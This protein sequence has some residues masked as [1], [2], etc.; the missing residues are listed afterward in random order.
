MI[1]DAFYTTFFRM[2]QDAFNTAF[3][4]VISSSTITDS[5][6]LQVVTLWLCLDKFGLNFSSFPLHQLVIYT[7][8][9]SHHL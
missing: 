6:T 4:R 2:I 1:Q 7:T 9:Q 3:F 8:F 5:L